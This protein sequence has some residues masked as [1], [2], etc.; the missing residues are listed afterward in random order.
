MRVAGIR[1]IE[2]VDH[3]TQTETSIMRVMKSDT[4]RGK[5]F[6]ICT[7]GGCVVGSASCKKCPWHESQENTSSTVR[8]RCAYEPTLKQASLL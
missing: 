2:A 3:P 5:A 8:V 7:E 1:R 6:K 4:Y